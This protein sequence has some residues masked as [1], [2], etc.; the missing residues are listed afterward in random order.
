[1]VYPT[2]SKKPYEGYRLLCLS[3]LLKVIQFKKYSSLR[4]TLVH[5]GHLPITRTRVAR[6]NK[7]T[8]NVAPDPNKRTRF[9]D[10]AETT[11]SEGFPP[12][13]FKNGS[14]S[15]PYRKNTV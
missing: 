3:I 9:F 15:A 2:I 8:H 14:K 11:P 4:S 1:L 5:E 13:Y 10:Q 12:F 7:R 6:K